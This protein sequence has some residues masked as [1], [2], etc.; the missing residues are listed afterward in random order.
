MGQI[1]TQMEAPL[2]NKNT[3]S[4][5]KGIEETSGGSKMYILTNIVEGVM[6]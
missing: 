1:K 5:L 2:S 3:S 6:A 4:S